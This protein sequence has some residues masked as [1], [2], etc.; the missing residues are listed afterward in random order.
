MKIKEREEIVRGIKMNTT[1]CRR[2]L[3]SLRYHCVC[4]V[5]DDPENEFIKD[6]AALDKAIEVLE[7]SRS[8]RAKAVWNIAKAAG[9]EA[10]VEY[11]VDDLEAF[12]EGL[13]ELTEEAV[14]QAVT[15]LP[16]D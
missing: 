6:V 7:E 16:R 4:F 12:A 2:Q 15:A 5:D 1:E 8:E 13:D 11:Y 9:L 14:I 10:A 3:K